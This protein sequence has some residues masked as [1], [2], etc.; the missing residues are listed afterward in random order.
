MKHIICNIKNQNKI[1]NRTVDVLQ[2]GGLI[3]FPTDTV[4]GLLC[5]ATNEQAVKKLI[6]FKNR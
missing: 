2:N 6:Q 5:D 1:I 3:I 4:Y